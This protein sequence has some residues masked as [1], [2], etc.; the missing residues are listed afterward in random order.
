MVSLTLRSG[1]GARGDLSQHRPRPT[2]RFIGRQYGF[3][4]ER[5]PSRPTET[6]AV[7][8]DIRFNAAGFDPKAEAWKF[9]IPIDPVSFNRFELI[10]QMDRQVG[11]R[12]SFGFGV[13]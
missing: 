6:I 4:T 3:S 2:T 10:Y 11:H 9:A 5:H 8:Y 7:L 1:I 12:A 13:L